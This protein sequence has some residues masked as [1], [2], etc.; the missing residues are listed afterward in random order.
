MKTR[1]K[2]AL[3]LMM[4]VPFILISCQKNEYNDKPETT[5]PAAGQLKTDLVYCGTPLVAPMVDYAQSIAPAT[6][7]V[8]NDATN[9]LVKFELS[10]PGWFINLP[11]LFIGTPGQLAALP[12]VTVDFNGPNTVYF[13]STSAPFGLPIGPGNY[14]NYG[15]YWEYSM[16]LSDLPECFAVVAYARIRNIDTNGFL[17]IWGKS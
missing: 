1:I 7:T 4:T 12:G 9:L 8:M 11:A 10:E 14:A 5:A 3:L 2:H 13:N 6:V 15:N 16:P 17:D